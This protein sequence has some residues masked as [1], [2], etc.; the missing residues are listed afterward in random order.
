MQSARAQPALSDL[1]PAPLADEEVSDRHPHILE[2]D[3]GMIVLVPKKSERSENLD[4]NRIA[5]YQYHRE[6]CV[7]CMH[8][9]PSALC[10][11]ACNSA[12]AGADGCDR[13]GEGEGSRLWTGPV[14][15][16]R[17]RNTKTLH[18][19]RIAPEMYLQRHSGRGLMVRQQATASGRTICAR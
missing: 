16:V 13:G 5:R 4:A 6:A 2:D 15:E 7:Y 11:R 12:H 3:L 14:S 18:S 10:V 19:G 1:E 9:L 17:P 8:A